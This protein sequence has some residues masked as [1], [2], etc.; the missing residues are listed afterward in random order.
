MKFEIVLI[1]PSVAV[2]GILSMSNDRP[3]AIILP[4]VVFDLAI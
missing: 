2:T 3:L 1:K 4:L